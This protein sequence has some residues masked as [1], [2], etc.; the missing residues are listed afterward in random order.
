M[1]NK[2]YKRRKV[3]GGSNA[4]YLVLSLC[5]IAV[6]VAAWSAVSTLNNFKTEPEAP[7]PQIEPQEEI[8]DE[9]PVKNELPEVEYET[10]APE[11]ETNNEVK[12]EET[13]IKADYFL[14][15][16]EEGKIVKNFD[17]KSLQYSSTF[18]DMRL[19]LGV[20]I[21][22]EEGTAVKSAGR[23]VVEE[24]YTD[25]LLGT[26][27]VINHGNEILAKYSG[28]SPATA[29]SVGDT[30]E[31]GNEIGT[32]AVVP[33]ESADSPHLHLEMYKNGAAVSP[34]KTMGFEE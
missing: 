11:E 32:I 17:E 15:P 20:D 1:E 31:A 28:L 34:L 26:T 3:K 23:G 29:V 5:L 33:A 22:A 21:S 6:G 9:T 27:V 10:P 4:F 13:E 16:I 30:L 25:D 19:H 2:T 8:S 12:N 7:A 24:I 14:M 18:S